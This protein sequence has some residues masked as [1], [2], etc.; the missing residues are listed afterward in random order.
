M[1]MSTFK[2]KRIIPQKYLECLM[3]KGKA[4]MLHQHHERAL[5]NALG[6]ATVDLPEAI[7][8]MRSDVHDVQLAIMYGNFLKAEQQ[9]DEAVALYEEAAELHYNKTIRG[10]DE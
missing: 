10:L 8:K 3:E 7:D 4:F 1:Q 5:A 6:V 2:S 9:L